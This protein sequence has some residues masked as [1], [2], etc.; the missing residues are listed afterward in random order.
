[1]HRRWTLLVGLLVAGGCFNAPDEGPP[2]PVAVQ[3]RVDAPGLDAF[4]IDDRDGGRWLDPAG[5]T[6]RV[7]EGGPAVL[8]PWRGGW[9]FTP[10][11]AAIPRGARSA[12]VTFTARRMSLR[13]MVESLFAAHAR[14]ATDPSVTP[15]HGLPPTAWKI[16]QPER[17]A[18]SNPT[19]WGYAM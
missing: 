4:R 10:A 8:A 17:F 12:A 18:Y 3:V 19:E 15:P 7:A 11:T 2:P 16:G 6:I 5:D 9:A 14:W 13:E 1:M